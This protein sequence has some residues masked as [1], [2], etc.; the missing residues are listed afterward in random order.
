VFLNDDFIEKYI[1]ENRKASAKII[2]WWD[3]D[4]ANIEEIKR[5]LK[6][7]DLISIKKILEGL[8]GKADH[9]VTKIVTKYMR[10]AEEFFKALIT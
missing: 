2:I 9:I 5:R 3:F 7:S 1:F 8:R 4:E 6:L 10:W